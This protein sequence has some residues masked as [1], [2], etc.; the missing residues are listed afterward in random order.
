MA[1]NGAVELEL[2]PCFI[3]TDAII[4]HQTVLIILVPFCIF[5]RA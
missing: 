2:I 5:V 1:A 3:N 4:D